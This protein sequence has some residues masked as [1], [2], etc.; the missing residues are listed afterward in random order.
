[1]RVENG[2]MVDGSPSNKQKRKKLFIR[3]YKASNKQ[4]NKKYQHLYRLRRR[5]TSTTCR[6]KRMPGPRKPP[7]LL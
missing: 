6:L 7:R 3:H 2:A 4:T 5:T 1:M